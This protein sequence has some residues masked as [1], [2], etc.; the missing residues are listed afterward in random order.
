MQIYFE[1]CPRNFTTSKAL[2]YHIWNLLELYRVHEYPWSWS[3]LK[4]CTNVLCNRLRMLAKC[5]QYMCKYRDQYWW[6]SHLL[7]YN[8]IHYSSDFL[9]ALYPMLLC[10]YPISLV[11]IGFSRIII[12]NW[13][14]RCVC[15]QIGIPLPQRPR[16]H[17]HTLW[18]ESLEVLVR[19]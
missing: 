14:I 5:S 3:L 18:H 7:L 13:H 11:S 6:I 12:H 8:E 15:W 19:A 9:Q 17:W 16:V 10:T 1:W 4:F 2:Y